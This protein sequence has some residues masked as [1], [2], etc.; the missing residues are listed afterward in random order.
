MPFSLGLVPFLSR[1]DQSGEL[2]QERIIRLPLVAGA[3]RFAADGAQVFPQHLRVDFENGRH[4]GRVQHFHAL[5]Y[6]Y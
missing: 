2:F 5:A 6:L 4:V 1:L 3:R